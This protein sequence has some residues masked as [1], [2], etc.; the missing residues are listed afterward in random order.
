MPGAVLML[1]LVLVL[2]FIS[3]QGGC[4]AEPLSMHWHMPQCGHPTTA[5]IAGGEQIAGSVACC[6]ENVAVLYQTGD[7]K[8]CWLLCLLAFWLWCLQ[9]VPR[10]GLVA[11]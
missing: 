6:D 3:E 4:P 9:A 5:C 7:V 1:M 2:N 11:A 10:S 8:A